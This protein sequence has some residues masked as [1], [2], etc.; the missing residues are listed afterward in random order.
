MQA[1]CRRDAFE[2]G[3]NRLKKIFTYPMLDCDMSQ[4]VIRLPA[5]AGDR[6]H[7]GGLGNIDP[8]SLQGPNV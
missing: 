6:R 2:H 8:A 7:S 4:N 5:N 1:W 3:N